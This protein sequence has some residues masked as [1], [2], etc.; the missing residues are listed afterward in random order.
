MATNLTFK[1]EYKPMGAS[2]HFSEPT[3]HAL[4]AKGISTG[5]LANRP[6]V[7]EQW[8]VSNLEG[9]ASITDAPRTSTGLEDV[10]A[11]VKASKASPKETLSQKFQKMKDQLEQARQRE[12]E[13]KAQ[14]RQREIAE[15]LGKELPEESEEFEDEEMDESAPAKIGHFLADISGDWAKEDMVGLNNKELETLAVRFHSQNKEG[16]FGE[17][18]NPF[19]DELKER[20]RAQAEMKK[21]KAQVEA[22][23]RAEL[24]NPQAKRGLLADLFT[25]EPEPTTR[26][27]GA[28]KEKGLL[29]DVLG[30]DEPTPRAKSGGQGKG[31]MKEFFD[32]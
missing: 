24:K 21:E 6:A 8:G 2:G 32:L 3:R 14:L 18:E 10:E 5:N 22:E 1:G 28:R 30:D 7:Y 9:K 13:H 27:A 31:F 29:Q 26:R 11:E 16:M 23:I 12:K 20:L 25:D 19:L 4:Q 17:P 15:G